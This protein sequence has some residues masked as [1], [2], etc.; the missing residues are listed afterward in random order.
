LIVVLFLEI[1][2]LSSHVYYKEWFVIILRYFNPVGAH[3]SGT[4]GEDPTGV[5]NNLMPYVAQVAIGNRPYLNVFGNDYNTIDGTGVRDYLHVM[6]LVDG[7]VSALKKILN[8]DE[9]GAVAINLGTGKGYSVLQVMMY[10]K[11][12]FVYV[13]RINLII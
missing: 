1:N 7:H 6:D 3:P 12:I 8:S 5:P 13:I 11:F 10:K 9:H 2:Y 4:L